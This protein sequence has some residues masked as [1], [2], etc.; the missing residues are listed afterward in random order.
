MDF[1]FTNR[2]NNSKTPPKHSKCYGDLGI[3]MQNILSKYK[4]DVEENR[5]PKKRDYDSSQIVN[6]KK[7]K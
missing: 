3:K 1:P 7:Q 6:T 2:K 4:L 5:F